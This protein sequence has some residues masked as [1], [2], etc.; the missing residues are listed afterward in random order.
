[1][2]LPGRGPLLLDLLASF[3]MRWVHGRLAFHA[4]VPIDMTSSASFGWDTDLV[5]AVRVGTGLSRPVTGAAFEPISVVRVKAIAIF[6]HRADGPALFCEVHA[7]TADAALAGTA[8][9]HHVGTTGIEVSAPA[10]RYD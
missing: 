8:A 1:M 10:C 3:H 9:E 5:R 6:P 2:I 4:A 7:C